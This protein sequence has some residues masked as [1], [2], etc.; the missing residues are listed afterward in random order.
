MALRLLC[1]VCCCCSV[2]RPNFASFFDPGTTS[3]EFGASFIVFALASAAQVGNV[4]LQ[5]MLN[6]PLLQE[7]D[8][9]FLQL[10]G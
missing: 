8:R 7:L 10:P 2:L 3:Q 6:K 4:P 9:G 1:L 5:H